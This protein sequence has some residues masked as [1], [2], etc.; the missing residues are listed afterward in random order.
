MMRITRATIEP[1]IEAM[2]T[3]EEL[4]ELKEY[5]EGWVELQAEYRN[6][7]TRDALR[8]N[9][10]AFEDRLEEIADACQAVLSIIRPEPTEKQLAAQAKQDAAAH[11][12][13]DRL[14]NA[15]AEWRGR[16]AR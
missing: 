12:A 9:R 14:K 10:E 15:R 5:M 3:L 7:E 1:L 13:A 6:E 16:Y 11:A 8:E 4:A 2:T